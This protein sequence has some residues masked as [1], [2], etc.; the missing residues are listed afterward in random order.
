MNLVKRDILIVFFVFLFSLLSFS[1]GSEFKI[2]E[3][4]ILSLE[5]KEAEIKDVL[6]MLAEQFGLNIVV[7]NMVE[8]KI[9]V[10]FTNVSVEEAIDAIVT[11]NGYAYTKKGSVIKVTTPEEI[12]R[13]APITRVFILNNAIA[14]DLKPSLLKALSSGGSIEVDKRSNALI[15]TDVPNSIA[16]VER[17]I[18]ELD[19]ET[20][21]VLIESRIIETILNDAVDLG[22]KWTA[23][24]TAT[25]AKRPHT[26]PFR[27][28]GP[29]SFF[30]E[31]NPG[32]STTGGT[33]S[34]SLFPAADGFPY[35]TASD[36]TFGT[37]NFSEFK[38]VL[39]AL[40]TNSETKVLSHPRLVT[41]NNQEAKILVGTRIPIPIYT[42]NDD[43]GTYEIS[44][45]DEEEV[46]IA[47]EVTPHVS[48]DNKVKLTL[49]PEVSSITAYTGPNNERP[50]ID[51]REASTQV[52]LRDGETVVIGGLIKKNTVDTVTKVPLLG[53]IPLLGLAFRHKD[54]TVESTDLLIFVTANILKRKPKS[55]TEEH[56]VEIKKLFKPE[57]EIR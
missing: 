1:E 47:L 39:E 16:T 9:S 17:L 33:T 50:I 14:E 34:S 57:K 28:T 29:K 45:Y 24:V 42:F 36:F 55:K 37:L 30:P 35:T 2:S 15:V 27:K 26:F 49:H 3:G 54:K 32:S 38:A 40:E 25:G 21:Q 48:P 43:T 52:Q 8:G 46:G 22:I 5:I 18:K 4:K 19:Q 23:K 20:P 41:L 13:E 44:G 12:E 56:V 51:T 7:S 11:I 31:N 53:D 10:K 6:R